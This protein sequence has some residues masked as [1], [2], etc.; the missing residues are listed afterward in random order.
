M[1][2][3]AFQVKNVSIN[4]YNIFLLYGE[5][6]GYKNQVIDNIS[7][8]YKPN[9]LKY[10]EDELIKNSDIFFSEVNNISLFDNK[11]VIIINRVSDKLLSLIE[12]VLDRKFDDLKIIINA[13]ILDRKSKL[14]AKFEKSKNLICIPFYADDNSMLGRIAN[15]F[16]EIKKYLFLKKV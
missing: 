9:I 13:G 7:K 14:R 1:I 4:S 15:D 11:K 12:S 3:K 16:L 6:E 10:E 5:N 8:D 2:I